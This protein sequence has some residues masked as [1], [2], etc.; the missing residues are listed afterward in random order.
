MNQTVN[1]VVQNIISNYNSMTY[2]DI[3]Y[4]LVELNDETAF[5]Q[6]LNAIPIH[7]RNKIIE[8]MRKIS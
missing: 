7:M 2:Q 4:R 8:M 6:V 1:Q 5:Q 3:F